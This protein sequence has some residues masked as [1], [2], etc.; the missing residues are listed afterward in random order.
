[1]KA[2]EVGLRN[3]YLVIVLVLAVIVVGGV[4]VTKIPADLLPQFKTRGDLRGH[5]PAISPSWS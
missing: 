5:R 4:A 3:P 2:I 1:M